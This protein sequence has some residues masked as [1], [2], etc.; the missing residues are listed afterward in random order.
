WND[1]EIAVADT[2]ASFRTRPLRQADAER[3]F[4]PPHRP[5]AQAEAARVAGRISLAMCAALLQIPGSTAR[6]QARPHTPASAHEL[7]QPAPR[8]PPGRWSASDFTLTFILRS[9]R[10]KAP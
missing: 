5:T 6:I 1:R 7:W 10:K 3:R 9:N 4:R 2:D 8:F